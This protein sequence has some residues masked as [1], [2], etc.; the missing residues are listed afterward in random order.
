MI[1]INIRDYKQSII[2]DDGKVIDPDDDVEIIQH[3]NLY[4]FVYDG[5]SNYCKSIKKIL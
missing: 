4:E 1:R 2:T 5:Y 3:I